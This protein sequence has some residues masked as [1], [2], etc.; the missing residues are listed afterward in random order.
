MQNDKLPFHIGELTCQI[1]GWLALRRV[2]AHRHSRES[3][4]LW[5][6]W[7]SMAGVML[8]TGPRFRADDGTQAGIA[9]LNRAQ[10]M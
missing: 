9:P 7:R 10:M 4:N 8:T 1:G 5:I 2:A 6:A 3:G